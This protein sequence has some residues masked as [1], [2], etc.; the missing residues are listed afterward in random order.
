MLLGSP[1]YGALFPV[2]MGLF[3][4]L[5][6]VACASLGGLR[7]LFPESV[8]TPCAFVLSMARRGCLVVR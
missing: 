2:V 6:L 7:Y 1:I 5:M 3:M 4:A 8:G